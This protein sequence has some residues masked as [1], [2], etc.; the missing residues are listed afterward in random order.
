MKLNILVSYPKNAYKCVEQSKKT[1]FRMNEK[2]LNEVRINRIVLKEKS[3]LINKKKVT[4]KNMLSSH[5]I[6]KT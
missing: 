5:G 3:H 1:L 2:R 4:K 6:Q